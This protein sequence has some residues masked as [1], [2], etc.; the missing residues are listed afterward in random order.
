MLIREQLEAGKTEKEITDFFVARYGDYVLMRPRTEG[1]GL[2]L[3]LFPPLLLLIAGATAYAFVRRRIRRA[4]PA[5]PQLSPEDAE[6][7][8]AARGE[9]GPAA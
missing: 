3:W 7:V 4:T 5:A 9:D 2:P 8:R 6:R 1:I